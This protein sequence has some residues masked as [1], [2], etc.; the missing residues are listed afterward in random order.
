[1]TISYGFYLILIIISLNMLVNGG[2]LH[3]RDLWLSLV[4][5]ALLKSQSKSCVILDGKHDV[6]V[7]AMR[8]PLG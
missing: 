2:R 6:F 3:P 1:M 7:V 8:R 5:G 4:Y